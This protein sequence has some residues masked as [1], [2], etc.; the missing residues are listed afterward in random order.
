[1]E[2]GQPVNNVVAHLVRGQKD[3]SFHKMLKVQYSLETA[4]SML[5]AW[6][7]HD[8]QVREIYNMF[9]K[10]QITNISRIKLLS[11]VHRNGRAG[12]V[13]GRKQK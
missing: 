8:D 9:D 7:S 11:Q 2:T 1:M 13:E 5:A 6:K 3:Q 4:W 10:G 12:G